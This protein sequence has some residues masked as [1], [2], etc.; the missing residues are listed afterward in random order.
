M[1]IPDGLKSLYK[2][3]PDHTQPPQVGPKIKLDID[4]V[5]QMLD[6]SSKRMQLWDKKRVNDSVLTKFRFCNIYR[7]LDRQTIEFHTLL[8]SLEQNFD[9]WLLN[10]AFCRF[11]CNPQT[12][13]AIG[14]LS[15]DIENNKQVFNKLKD[16]RSPK[17]G[18]A[19]I[20]PIST[21]MKSDYPTREDFFCLYL[22]MVIKKCGNVIKTFNKTS[23][24]EAL[25]K[26][27]PVFGFGLRFHWT[28]ILIDVA[29]QYPEYLDLFKA[30]PIGPGSG[31]TMLRLNPSADPIQTCLSLPKTAYL[32]WNN[33]PVWLSAENWEGVGCE[34]RKYSNLT[35]GHGR[36]RIY[37]HVHPS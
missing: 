31:P 1:E 5:D 12:I 24:V 34:F 21:I 15:F 29:Y 17:Y 14:L 36:R 8:K 33:K 3:W 2:H 13:K 28:E 26:V 10:M 32:T 23:V 27:I 11:I 6:F 25:E 4:V 19:Y 7:E 22:P 37:T 9:L 35:A 16:L 18:T 20:F 30:F